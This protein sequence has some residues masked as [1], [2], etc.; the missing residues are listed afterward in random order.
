MLE[1]VKGTPAEDWAVM[2]KWGPLR[3]GGPRCLPGFCEES[4]RGGE[5]VP[6]EQEVVSRH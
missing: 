6:L 4:W 2:G 5:A 3:R 1:R